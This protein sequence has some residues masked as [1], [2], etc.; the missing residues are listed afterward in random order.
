MRC[1]GHPS[2]DVISKAHMAQELLLSLGF[3]N[4]TL[5]VSFK[6]TACRW[7][8]RRLEVGSKL[9]NRSAGKQAREKVMAL[10]G[11]REPELTLPHHDWDWVIKRTKVSRCEQA[12][13]GASLVLNEV[14]SF[15]P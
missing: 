6:Y 13:F 5:E 10:L 15:L 2:K 11:P 4:H 14:G 3:W 8:T 9:Q 7:H 1:S 12:P